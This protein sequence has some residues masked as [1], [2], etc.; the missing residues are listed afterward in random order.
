L[1]GRVFVLSYDVGASFAR[2]PSCLRK[3]SAVVSD[4]A[5][6]QRQRCDRHQLDDPLHE[7]AVGA[8]PVSAGVAL[9]RRREAKYLGGTKGR[10]ELQQLIVDRNGFFEELHARWR[11]AVVD[12]TERLRAV[13]VRLSARAP[14]VASPRSFVVDRI[15]HGPT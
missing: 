12:E 10:C 9:A 8:V 13:N 2:P 5:R 14:Q 11:R 1:F 15:R 4:P 3:P 7:L 6:R